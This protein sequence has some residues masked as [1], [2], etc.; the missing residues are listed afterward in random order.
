MDTRAYA[1][2]LEAARSDLEA[3]MEQREEIEKKISG[4]KQTIIALTRLTGSNKATLYGLGAHFFEDL[5]ITDQCR[6]VIRTAGKPMTPVE[7]RDQLVR[8]GLNPDK[9][10]NI[11]ASVH[12]ILKRL[13]ESKEI[14]KVTREDGQTAY[15][16]RIVYRRKLRQ[17]AFAGPPVTE[18]T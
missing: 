17:R 15:R 11:M 8:M 10:T 18:E 6:E 2:M 5:G 13:E 14:F 3:A 9:Y 16:Q 7:V 4:L 12:R 1:N